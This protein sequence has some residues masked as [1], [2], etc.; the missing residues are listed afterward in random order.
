MTNS[1]SAG[2]ARAG[3]PTPHRA[4]RGG[5]RVGCRAGQRAVDLRL[6]GWRGVTTLSPPR[7]RTAGNTR[8]R[9]GGGYATASHPDRWPA[10]ARFVAPERPVKT[11]LPR[12]ASRTRRN[13]GAVVS[14][15][16][17]RR[18][19][20]ALARLRKLR[21]ARWRPRSWLPCVRRPAHRPS[22]RGAG[23]GGSGREGRRAT[24]PAG[25][26]LLRSVTSREGATTTEGSIAVDTVINW[27]KSALFGSVLG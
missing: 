17:L 10:M 18:S 27:I 16:S 21:R 20:A 25:V 12:A 23:V 26:A 11:A 14:L 9:S 8:A 3:S 4:G 15:R 13:G 5:F 22:R 6:A 1:S 7:R 19:D 2:S 24:R